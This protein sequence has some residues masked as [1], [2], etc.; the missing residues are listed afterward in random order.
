MKF[1]VEHVLHDSPYPRRIDFIK[2]IRGYSGLGLREA[3]SICDAVTFEDVQ[4]IV[5]DRVDPTGHGNINTLIVEARCA[6]INLVCSQDNLT[7]SLHNA[8]EL[9]VNDRDY[10]TSQ[11]LLDI[12]IDLSK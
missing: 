11:R 2:A 6:G 8:L 3:K 7:I 1:K 12:L 5:V 9:A 4:T 10:D